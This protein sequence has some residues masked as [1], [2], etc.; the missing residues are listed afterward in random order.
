MVQTDEMKKAHLSIAGIVQGVGYRYSLHRQAQ[1]LGLSGWC[2]NTDDGRVEAEACGT[3]RQ[4]EALIAWCYQGPPNAVVSQ[5]EVT[6]APIHSL[7]DV[8]SFEI[9]R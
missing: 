4:L 3:N 9:I 7:P 1:A 8:P 5:V 6:Y 2:R